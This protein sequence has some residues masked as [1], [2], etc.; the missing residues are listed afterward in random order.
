M[1]ISDTINMKYEYNAI[2]S[3]QDLKVVLVVETR[4]KARRIARKKYSKEYSEKKTYI[5][6]SGDN[7]KNAVSLYKKSLENAPEKKERSLSPKKKT[8]KNNKP[9]A[10]LIQ[11]KKKAS[12]KVKQVKSQE[13]RKASIKDELFAEE[14]ESIKRMNARN[15]KEE[16]DLIFETK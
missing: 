10:T 5:I 9:K 15:L 16:S 6:I 11:E 2:V 13:K 1:Y 3:R 4:K 8:D 12:K 14:E 7:Y